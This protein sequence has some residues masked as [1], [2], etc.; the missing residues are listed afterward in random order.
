MFRK[1]MSR[2]PSYANSLKNIK[3]NISLDCKLDIIEEEY[4]KGLVELME[5]DDKKF[6]IIKEAYFKSLRN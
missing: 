3:S 6:T 5:D 1:Y 4:K 2:R